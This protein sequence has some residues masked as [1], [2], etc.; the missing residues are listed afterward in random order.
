M[1]KALRPG[2]HVFKFLRNS[3][4]SIEMN[5]NGSSSAVAF[6][7]TVPSGRSFEFSRHCIVMIDGGIGYNEFGGLGATLTNGLK[8]EF[9]DA[10]DAVLLDPLDGTTIKTNEDFGALAGTDNLAQPG[11]GDDSFP[12]RWTST[13]A[14]PGGAGMA[15]VSGEKLVVTVQDN[16]TGLTKFRW[17]IQGAYRD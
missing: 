3:S 1:S 6:S 13:R 11:V 9:K 2:Q 8:V 14:V 10:S 17:M 12:I 7:W 15:M 5:V 4:D 16:L